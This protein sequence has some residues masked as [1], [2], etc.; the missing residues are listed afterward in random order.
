VT[1]GAP[2]LCSQ[3]GN[4]NVPCASVTICV[5]GTTSCQTI[6]NVL[7]DTGSYGLRLFSQAVLIS[8][9]QVLD[10]SSKPV[11]ECAQFGTGND[12]GPV[13]TAD[14]I[15]AGEPR[16]TTSIQVINSTYAGGPPT[17]TANGTTT[18]SCPS[19]DTAPT[20]AGFNGILGVGLYGEDCGSGCVT[21]MANGLYFSCAGDTCLGTALAGAKQVQNPVGLL[22]VDNNGVLMNLP[23]VATGGTTEVA[24]SLILGIGTETNNIPSGVNTFLA[25]PYGNIKTI[26]NSQTMDS[27]IDS[28]SN[29]YFLPAPSTLVSCAS[30]SDASGWFC[31][32]S[33][34]VLSATNVS[35]TTATFS[36]ATNDYTCTGNEVAVT[37]DIANAQTLFGG[38]FSAFNDL[39]ANSTESG[40]ASS[41]DF[42]IDFF[43]G[44]KIYVGLDTV[45]SSLGTGPYWA[46]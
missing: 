28:G 13:M 17:T 24:G 3:P 11:A 4:V 32:A 31:P 22:P 42:G 16:V 23:V 35:C 12:W 40:F 33:T 30:T 25:D 39:G 44:R 1:V 43:Y 8:L 26:F 15:L 14:V 18:S 37:V 10:A 36:A 9:P 46:Y 20:Q 2:G 41:F 5:P 19:P 6:S 7:V 45:K 27:F 21:D 38:G 29:G 34:T